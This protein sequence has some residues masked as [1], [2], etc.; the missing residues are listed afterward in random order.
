MQSF[1]FKIKTYTF[2]RQRDYNCH[3]TSRISFIM[4]NLQAVPSRKTGMKHHISDASLFP[5]LVNFY[6]CSRSN[7]KS[8]KFIFEM[9]LIGPPEL[10]SRTASH[11]LP[12]SRIRDTM[13]INTI[14]NIWRSLWNCSFYQKGD[15][16]KRS[17][18]I[19]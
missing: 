14:K 17:V 10:K 3:K 8:A 4:H 5:G 16:S 9:K 13:K 1:C 7:A 6:G 11:V 19:M 15:Q 18:S 12:S 2:C